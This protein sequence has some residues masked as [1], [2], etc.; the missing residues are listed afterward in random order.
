MVSHYRCTLHLRPLR[1]KDQPRF[2]VSHVGIEVLFVDN[3][4]S[5]GWFQLVPSLNPDRAWILEARGSG[6]IYLRSMRSRRST[7]PVIVVFFSFF[8]LI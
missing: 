6:A 4:T 2:R 8:S 3:G 7:M 5:D 1:G